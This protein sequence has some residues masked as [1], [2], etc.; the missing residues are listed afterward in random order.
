MG[1]DKEKDVAL[2]EW[3][4]EGEKGVLKVSVN[5][6]NDGDKKLQIGP[7]TFEKRGGS[8]GYGKAGRLTAD[9]T[10]RLIEILPE[11]LETING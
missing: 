1:W 7:R 6:Y 8:T 9:E 2:K 4:I 10:K 11:A 5:S 3:D